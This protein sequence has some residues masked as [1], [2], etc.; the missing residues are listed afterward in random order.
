MKDIVKW[1]GIIVLCLILYALPILTT[2]SICEGWL[3]DISFLLVICCCVEFMF[4][5]TIIEREVFE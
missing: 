2:V 4:L 5:I 3:I 1:V